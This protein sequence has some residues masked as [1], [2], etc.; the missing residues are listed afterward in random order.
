MS[1]ALEE[2][3][4]LIRDREAQLLGRR[5]Q[6]ARVE[7]RWDN[8]GAGGQGRYKNYQDY[9]DQETGEKNFDA[10]TDQLEKEIKEL[11]DEYD[12]EEAIEDDKERQRKKDF[13]DRE[14]AERKRG[15]EPIE[16]SAQAAK[17]LEG[18]AKARRAIKAGKS[19]MDVLKLLGRGVTRGA[20]I[21][22]E[23]LSIIAGPS[24]KAAV[25]EAENK[26]KPKI[27]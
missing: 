4:K 21:P 15:A 20:S 13:K 1:K 24:M 27:I 17:L 10:N 3:G 2:L 9:I 26:D 6:G 5:Q 16:R 11:R 23:L 18:A 7:N 14:E 8:M 19:G 12:V 22:I 25:E